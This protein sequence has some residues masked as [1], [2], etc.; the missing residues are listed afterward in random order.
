[1][2]ALSIASTGML[3]QQMNVEVIA[4][5]IANM[6]TTGFKRQRA[7]FQDLLYENIE[8]PGGAAGPDTKAPSGFQIGAGVKTGG[9]YR[10]QQQGALQ[11]T[12]NRY[13]VA[14]TGRGYFQITLAS[15]A[16]AP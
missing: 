2:R 13:D 11:Q 12:D 5:N 10:I 1:M 16:G 9:V 4:N 3:A 6:N 7:E 15:A 14:I 8:R